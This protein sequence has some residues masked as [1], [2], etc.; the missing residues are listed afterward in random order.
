MCLFWVTGGRDLSYLG[1]YRTA[2]LA[3]ILDIRTPFF[4]SPAPVPWITLPYSVHI[5]RYKEICTE[6]SLSQEAKVTAGKKKCLLS[7]LGGFRM[8]P[9]P[10]NLLTEM[11]TDS[12]SFPE[13]KTTSISHS[14]PSWELCPSQ[15]P[16]GLASRP[17]RNSC[18]QVPASQGLLLILSSQ[19]C[20]AESIACSKMFTPDSQLQPMACLSL[21]M[22]HTASRKTQ[23]TWK[24]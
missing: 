1:R 14:R 3:Q 2:T 22:L 11:P 20:K 7:C 15:A 6:S 10:T 21:S 17:R 23:G 16:V 13:W 4:Q 8:L 24:V 19:G 5:L 12:S 9:L 18:H